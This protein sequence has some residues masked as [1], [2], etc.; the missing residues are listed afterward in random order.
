MQ[1]ATVE[2]LKDNNKI[3]VQKI[4]VQ[5]QKSNPNQESEDKPLKR[6]KGLKKE[7]K[8][9]ELDVEEEEFNIY[10]R[11]TVI[12]AKKH[13]SATRPKKELEDLNEQEEN[14]H[15]CPCCLPETVK[16]KVEYFKT[17]D[18]PDSFSTCGQGVVLYYDYIK[19]VIIVSC[20]IMIIL[21]LLSLF[22]S[23]LR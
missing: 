4:E 6:K 16:G 10:S 12:N 17:C 11:G 21:N 13:R 9:K 8:S 7:I 15:L 3:E 23:L 19:F 5:S 1:E 2:Q 20:Y 18:N 22:L 14:D